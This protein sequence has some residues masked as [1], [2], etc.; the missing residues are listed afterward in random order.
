[1]SIT[2]TRT[3]SY[4]VNGSPVIAATSPQTG[5][6][7]VDLDVAVPAS[8][9]NQE[10]D[11]GWTET[12]LKSVLLYSDSAVTIKTNSSGTPQDTIA[13]AAGQAIAW[14]FGDPGTA[15]FAGTVTKLFITNGNTSLANVKVRALVQQ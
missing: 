4:S 9:T 13:L 6:E 5:D 3:T 2:H 14:Q 10:Y 1:M 15:P 11:I 8:V 12:A 7:E